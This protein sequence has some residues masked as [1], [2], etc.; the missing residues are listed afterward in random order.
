MPA[1]SGPT[2]VL[3]FSQLFAEGFLA[4]RHDDFARYFQ[5]HHVALPLRKG[6]ALFFSPSLF[7]AAGANTTPSTPR[8]ANLLQISSAF[9][10]P[11]ESTDTVAILERIWGR[12]SAKFAQEGW[13]REVEAL[14]QAPGGRAPESEQ[15]VLRRGLEG[16]WGVKEV[17]EVVKGLRGTRRQSLV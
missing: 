1:D 3:P 15:G 13:S 16:G 4:P 7:H 10:K 11:M 8:S 5:H 17:K 2:R 6:D 9:G 14:V 12:L